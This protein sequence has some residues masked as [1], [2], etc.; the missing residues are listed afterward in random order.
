MI[1]KWLCQML[2]V[3]PLTV[4][5]ATFTV[6]NTDSSGPSTLRQAILDANASPGTDIIN[7]S[8][9]GGQ[10][11]RPS[12]PLPP[13]TDPVI[14]DGSSQP[15]YSG[16]PVIELNGATAGN[17]GVWGLLVAA[18]NCSIRGVAINQFSGDAIV[19]TNGTGASVQSCYLGL[20]RDGFTRRGNGGAGVR[21]AGPAGST[22][23]IG[24]S[25]RFQRN[26][27]SGNNFGIY[28]LNSPGNLVSGNYIGTDASGSFHV[29]N[30]NSGI[31][32][33]GD[34]A[35]WNTIGGTNL[36]KR[37]LISGN[38]EGS[39]AQTADGITLAACWS[40]TVYGNYIGVD[41]AG[42]TALPNGQHGVNVLFGG[43][44]HQIG[45]GV[46]GAGNLISGNLASGINLGGGGGG[47]AVDA[48]FIQGN[49]IGTDSS[50]EKA[51]GNLN[52]GIFVGLNGANLIG[53][54]GDGQ[55]NIISA[56]AYN[57]ITVGCCGLMGNTILGNS[58]GT[59]VSGR[60]LGNGG[61]GIQ[62]SSG[63][64][65]IGGT[66]V[67]QGNVIAGNLSG[68]V[69][70]DYN[71]TSVPILGNCIYSNLS[72]GID[73]L[74]DYGVNP[75][76]PGDADQGAN[77]SQ[78]YPVITWALLNSN[79]VAI[80]GSLNSAGNSSFLIELF[81]NANPNASGYGEGQT[82]LAW[83]PVVT[84]G[85]GNVS[86]AYTNPAP[87][88]FGHYITATATDNNGN[89]SEFSLARKIVPPDSIDLALTLRDSADPAPRATNF[90]YF[91]TVTNQGPANATA[92]CVTNSLP[93][94]IAFVSAAPSQGAVTNMGG[95]LVWDVGGLILGQGA[96]LRLE[97][98]GLAT[99]LFTNQAVCCASEFDNNDSNNRATDTT[100]VGIADLGVRV[101]DSPEPGVAGQIVTYSIIVSNAGPDSATSASVSFF[102]DGADV[103]ISASQTQGALTEYGN[104]FVGDL[105]LIPPHSSAVLTIVAI[106]T[107]AGLSYNNASA[108][109]SEYD[110][111][112]ANDSVY[113]T[114]T[115]QPGAGI[116]DFSSS[117]FGVSEGAG[118]A[119]ITVERLAGSSGN[120][121][122][123]FS[124]QDGTAVAG[125]DYTATNGTL[126]FTNGETTKTFL[127]PITDDS[128][129]ECNESLLLHLFNPTGGAVVLLRT[130]AELEIF[131]NDLTPYGT[132]KG[133]SLADPT[134]NATADDGSYQISMTDDGRYI[135]FASSAN[136][137]VFSPE[138]TSN[139]IYRYDQTGHSNQLISIAPDGAAGDN[140]SFSPQ[141]SADG[142]II[143]FLSSASNLATNT[144]AAQQLYVRNLAAG[145][146][147][148]ASVNTNGLG[149]S[150][151]V[152]TFSLA[153]NGLNIAFQSYATD[154]V[155]GMIDTNS[156][157]DI[158]FHDVPSGTN[159]LVSI[160]LSGTGAGNAY[161]DHPVLS[162]NGRFVL[163]G[164]YAS[165]LAPGDTNS[166]YDIFLRDVV[167][168]TTALVSANPLG[169]AGNNQCGS[170]YFVS[171]DGRYVAFESYATDL[172]PGTPPS[173][174]QVFRKDMLTGT[175][176]IA[177]VKNASSA[178]NGNVTLTGMSRD[179]RFVMFD[180]DANNVSNN[181]T[182][183]GGDVFIRDMSA[184]RTRLVSVNTARTGPADKPSFSMALSPSGQYV[185]FSSLAD[186]LTSASVPPFVNELYLR[187][188]TA[189]STVLLSTRF[190]TNVGANGGAYEAAVSSSGLAAFS[191][192][193]TDIAQV[194]ANSGLDIFMRAFGDPAPTLVTPAVGS[195]GGG[196]SYQSKLSAD[197]SSVVFQ[198]YAPNLVLH[199]AN[200]QPDVF[201]RDLKADATRLVSINAAG[202]GSGA[203][204]SQ[205]PEASQDGRFVVFESSAPDLVTNDFNGA[206]DVFLRDT[207]AGSTLLVSVNRSGNA[208]GN[209][210]SISPHLTPD[211]QFIVFESLAGNLVSNDL[212][213]ASDIFLRNRTNNLVELI[214]V[215]GTGTASG[216]AESHFPVISANGRWVAFDSRASNL[217]PPDNNNHSDVYV[218]DRQTG[219][220]ILCSIN[221]VG[222]NGGNSDSYIGGISSNGQVVVFY[223]FATDLVPNDTN[224]LGQLFA[225]DVATRTV[226]L[227]SGTPSD[228][229]GSGPA[230]QPV[231]SADGR[232]VVFES[233][234]TNLVPGMSSDG[235]MQLYVRDLVSRV[236]SLVSIN[237]AG[238]GAGDADS[239]APAI[240][241]DGR[242][243][244]FESYA[245]DLT[246][247]FFNFYTRN[248]YRRDLQTGITVLLSR[249]RFQ[250]GGGNDNS[251]MAQMSADGLVVAF[252]S[253]ASDLIANDANKAS[254]VFVWNSSPVVG[255]VDLV[256]M[257]DPSASSVL[258]GSNIIYTITFTNSG[259]ATANGVKVTDPLPSGMPFVSA[260]STRG[261]LTNSAGT[262]IAS[263]GSLPPGSGGVISICVSAQA[264]GTFTNSAVA[265]SLEADLSPANNVASTLV[266][267][268]DAPPPR[269]SAVVTN[270]G[271][272]LLQWPS[273][274]SSAYLLEACTNFTPVVVW[275]PV[276]NS[277]ADDGALRSVLL[278]VDTNTPSRFYR[279]R[280]P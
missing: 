131:D 250:S 204:Y 160:N 261:I 45:S 262:V 153:T 158:F 86:F 161:S 35:A 248:V 30:T 15:G 114:T 44:D 265:S 259:T 268:C 107:I 46:P 85:D 53:G 277:V 201:I 183:S 185:V 68:G 66:D 260:N 19:I 111:N 258:Q 89:T 177:S 136:N 57:G 213:N 171:A 266:T 267:V 233:Q 120:V 162:A 29:G 191:S 210:D 4:A 122:V 180:T 41:A 176:V 170:H 188:M 94:G 241:A 48:D 211:G 234:S 247:G 52:H 164:S 34:N 149:S 82:H 279:L 243:I 270:T 65:A 81:D 274:T 101:V 12:S 280:K 163:F 144:S 118:A 9:A 62:A 7:F 165:D 135:A 3:L 56:N 27:I 150:D 255:G 64:T 133:V 99:G 78:N 145:T 245:S 155:A 112:F 39:S 224:Y 205:N 31:Y 84:H 236:T 67:N 33:F 49:L 227:I 5:A 6:T 125:S 264:V 203:G 192:Y 237:C 105:G 140:A 159:A 249:N 256:L 119:L 77:Q 130:N 142:S 178:A 217:G 272:L 134:I 223:S 174:R 235:T 254:D 139:Q 253:S 182:N 263:I 218:R 225:F 8:L 26:F 148:L 72:L 141:I 184:A 55:G 128:E 54:S 51:L 83:V 87:L 124:T 221:L 273:A 219:S 1:C 16:T 240:S 208:S 109:R 80:L 42:S 179:G 76:D 206:T 121:S 166:R 106:P 98:A 197:G 194:D 116:L 91:L 230:Y 93:D 257:E 71:I 186:D 200:G 14:I 100:L 102:L 38:G 278:N 95:V 147:A 23:T 60:L 11:I 251:I 73:L 70:V 22:N 88:P 189:N 207:L 157:A 117:R 151:A 50:G 239:Y 104:Y 132:L 231:I 137:L 202:T 2:F 222:N 129:P 47:L 228:I 276:T 20:D 195:T 92:V 61:V 138:Q 271:Q 215:N 198:G 172:A 196:W 59:T 181:D 43:G 28:V 90:F 108:S 238:T 10:V 37:N 97:V 58:I 75:N 209:A 69:L 199:D 113:E 216:N 168:R 167:A 103:V 226:Q 246:P 187:D 127:V 32:V 269:L 74:P 123:S 193:A 173:T 156:T 143:A 63:Q 220:N 244:A 152:Y 275:S 146:T 212:N 169:L 17:P 18:R 13:L 232:Y 126:V 242:Y 190:G 25:L 40:N 96:A 79:N 36:A 115:V 252:T 110:P 214:S 175:T 21:I 154:L 229:P 24:G